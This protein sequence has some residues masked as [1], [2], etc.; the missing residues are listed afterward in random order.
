MERRVGEVPAGDGVRTIHTQVELLKACLDKDIIVI[1]LPATLSAIFQPLYA[2][3]CG[4]M[5]I[6][7]AARLPPSLLALVKSDL[8]R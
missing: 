1:N 2:E 6:C 5:K 3:F 7:H 4:E 8:Y